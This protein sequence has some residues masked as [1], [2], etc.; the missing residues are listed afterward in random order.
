MLQSLYYSESL[1]W[2]LQQQWLGEMIWGNEVTVKDSQYQTQLKFSNSAMCD[3]FD[4][5]SKLNK[6]RMKNVQTAT[7]IRR[8]LLRAGNDKLKSKLLSDLSF[9]VKASS[10]NGYRSLFSLF[11]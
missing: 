6:N 8:V 2:R 1:V 3:Y 11:N 4:S 10:Y 5:K 9:I 7:R